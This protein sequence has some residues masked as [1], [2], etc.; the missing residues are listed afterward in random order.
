MQS[1]YSKET[2]ENFI[3]QL[4]QK[5][6]EY[7]KQAKPVTLHLRTGK[8]KVIVRITI[9]PEEVIISENEFYLEYKS[10][11]LNVEHKIDYIK[12][13]DEYEYDCF[14]VKIDDTEIFF[15]FI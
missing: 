10:F 8:E 9:I 1:D 6:I 2:N 3:L 13:V 12:Y 14:Y 4:S 15:D 7:M 11:I 5:L